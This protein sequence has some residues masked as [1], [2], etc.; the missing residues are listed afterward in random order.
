M[1]WP[2]QPKETGV[3]CTQQI[4]NNWTRAT[5]PPRLLSPSGRRSL[6]AGGLHGPLDNFR[7]RVPPPGCRGLFFM[8]VAVRSSARVVDPREVLIPY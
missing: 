3:G 1:L 6:S 8:A 2:N 5:N 4:A 7:P